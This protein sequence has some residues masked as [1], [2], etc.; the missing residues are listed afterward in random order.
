MKN[1]TFRRMPL[2]VLAISLALLFSGCVIRDNNLSFKTTD[3]DVI[4]VD[5]YDVVQEETPSGSTKICICRA[6]H[7]RALQLAS[8]MWK[9]RQVAVD[10]LEIACGINTPGP[11]EFVEALEGLGVI[12]EPV[13]VDT[14]TGGEYLGLYNYS[15]LVTNTATGKQVRISP[16]PE[17]YSGLTNDGHA[18][19]HVEFFE[20]RRKIKTGT[21]TEEDK[22]FFKEQIRPRVVE[23]FG[24]LPLVNMYEVAVVT[25]P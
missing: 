8:A 19:D 16:R 15:V 25:N 11:E 12:I 3:G 24:S 7:F 5:Y 13:Q 4:T 6:V 20:L 18:F 14:S 10:E 2:V 21:A 9:K 17:L 23:N 1:M 22:K